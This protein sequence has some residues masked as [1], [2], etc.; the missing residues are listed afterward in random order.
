[1][2]ATPAAECTT[3]DDLYRASVQLSPLWPIT[4]PD[5]PLLPDPTAP[6]LSRF[7]PVYRDVLARTTSRRDGQG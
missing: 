3:K 2:N 6:T 7:L 4:D 5:L 1:M